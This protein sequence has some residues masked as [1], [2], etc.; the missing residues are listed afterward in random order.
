M[1]IETSGVKAAIERL[2]TTQSWTLLC[3]LA[4]TS[5]VDGCGVILAQ[6]LVVPNSTDLYFESDYLMMLR[7]QF[8]K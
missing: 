2:E 1:R 3:C 8:F 6:K 4:H 7:L 5:C